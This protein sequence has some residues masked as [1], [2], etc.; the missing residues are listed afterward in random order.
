MFLTISF[1]SFPISAGI[2]KVCSKYT[3]TY[4]ELDPSSSYLVDFAR[5]RGSSWGTR[6][7]LRYVYNPY[8]DEENGKK[9]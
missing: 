7:D 4:P 9:V 6:V 2:A 1:S 5:L 3:T 8:Y